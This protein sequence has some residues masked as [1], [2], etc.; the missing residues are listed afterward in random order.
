MVMPREKRET[1][2]L[3]LRLPPELH[4]ELARLADRNDRSLNAEM[5]NRLR[6]A[7]SLDTRAARETPAKRG[8]KK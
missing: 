2:N 4:A 8:K 7:V 3:V 5:V 1:V 6:A